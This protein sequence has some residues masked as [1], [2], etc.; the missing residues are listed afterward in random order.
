MV[1]FFVL[2]SMRVS[3]F[4]ND[5]FKFALNAL[6]AF[7][8]GLFLTLGV[9]AG[10]AQVATHEAD[11]AGYIISFLIVNGIFCGSWV[12]MGVKM[13]PEKFLKWK[14][15]SAECRMALPFGLVCVDDGS[16]AAFETVAL[17]AMETTTVLPTLEV[18]TQ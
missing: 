7:S 1:P 11:Y 15:Y 5:F 17:T 10:T 13:I 6:F 8:Y 4:D 12:A 14:S 9:V 3:F 2:S 18:P 16:G